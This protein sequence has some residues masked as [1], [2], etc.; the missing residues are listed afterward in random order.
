M[1]AG[2]EVMFILLIYG[3]PEFGGNIAFSLI[4]IISEVNHIIEL[5]FD[6][7][8]EWYEYRVDYFN[9][10]TVKTVKALNSLSDEEL[11]SI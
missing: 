1:G 7:L 8:M 5:K 2:S 6:I 4:E 9:L 11:R 3:G 10:K